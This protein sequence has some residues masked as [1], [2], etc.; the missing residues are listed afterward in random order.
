MSTL[1]AR[2][3]RIV[4]ALAQTIF[5]PDRSGIT[6]AIDAGVVEYV[7]RWIGELESFERLQVRSMFQLFEYSIAV[8]TMRPMLRFTT[9]S[10]AQRD[11]F[12]RGWM[13]STM[14]ARRMAFN[15]LRSV[16]TLAYLASPRVSEEIKLTLGSEALDNDPMEHLRNLAGLAGAA[17]KGQGEEKLSKYQAKTWEPGQQAEGPR[18]P[19][20][21]ATEPLQ[22][23]PKGAHVHPRGGLFLPKQDGLLEFDDYRNDIVEQCDFVIVGSGPGGA[24]AARYLAA[25]GKSVVVVEAGGVIRREEFVRDAGF[26]LANYY[27]DS[28]L[29]TTRGNVIMPTMQPRVVGGGSVL[30]SAICLRMPEFSVNTW[31]DEHGVD[32]SFQEMERHYDIVEEFMGVKPVEPE[33]QGVRNELFKQAADALGIQADVIKRNE[34]DCKGTSH[35]NL[36]CPNGAKLSTDL[37]G[38]PEAI[39]DG[40]K[41][42]SSV[43]VERVLTSGKRIR[44][45][46]GV[47]RNPTTGEARGTLRVFAKCTIL[48]AGAIAS[49]VILQKSGIRHDTIGARLGM[50]PATVVA[51]I[52]SDD[53]L[54]WFGATQGYHST[55][56]LQEGIKLESLWADAALM[57][58]RVPGMGAKF[59]QHITDYRKLATWDAWVSGAS[60]TGSVKH[61]PGLP[62]PLVQYNLGQGD[63]RRLQAGT[64]KL[65]EMF[66]AAG[67]KYVYP[68][69]EGLPTRIRKVDEIQ[70]IREA[71]VTPQDIPA[72]SNHVYG[73]MCMGA[74]PD[75]HATDSWGKV[76]GY[77]DLYICDTGLYPSSPSA[78]PMLPVMALAHRLAEELTQRY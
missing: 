75:R 58:F 12:L 62:R 38:I 36:G 18:A 31:R 56:F 41:V 73:G 63:V 22:D 6:D 14:Y 64:V 47:M 29:R 48:A 3:R 5:P 65:A 69:I 46:E 72:G 8:T 24:L 76:H 77:D 68:G 23:K 19:F 21:Q 61:V 74:D 7:D 33:V 59:K 40:A 37:R 9:A 15:A 17:R 11:T 71:D 50:H 45:V 27:W 26:T 44:G 16:F 52:F 54:P 51:G 55:Q 70:R 53:V 49:P 57:A 30:N 28:G 25:Q 67:A 20:T 10:P 39:T 13:E 60:S 43:T 78:N 34:N 32:I 35:C 1:N 4:A 66:F 42:Y 2:E